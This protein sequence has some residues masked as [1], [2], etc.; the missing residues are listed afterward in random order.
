MS[1]TDSITA[2]VHPDSSEFAAL[3]EQIAAGAQERERTRERPYEV[4]DWLREAGF[5]R[6]RIPVEEGGAGLSVQE[7][8]AALIALAAA[9]SNAAH[10]LRVHFAFVEQQLVNPDAASRARWLDLVNSGAIIGN[11]QSEQNG[12]AVAGAGLETRAEPDPDGTGY[13]LTGVKYY[14]TGSLYADYIWVF[15]AAPDNR[16]AGIVIPADRDGVELVDDWDGFGQRLTGTGTTRFTDVY[17]EPD[18]YQDWGPAG[19]PLPPTVM[20]AFLQ[21]FLQAVTAGVLRAVR[22]DA[23]AL[24]RRRARSFG[25]AS[26]EAPAE[27]VQVLQ[28]VGEIAADAFAAEAIV[29]AAASRIDDAVATVVEGFPSLDAAYE[30]QVA[31]AQAKVAID[32]FSY[33]TAARLF[34]AGGASATQAAWQLDRHWRNVRTV[35]THNPTFL[36]ATAVGKWFVGGEAPPQNGFF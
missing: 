34:D 25:H 27:D 1:A 10:I 3:L 14:S 24:V 31:A 28:V 5:G 15:A 29:L 36:K 17:V 16:L 22:R 13:R 20:G 35:S 19:Q 30:A 23:A 33:A 11:A 9:D 7:L 26:A 2:P 21:L 12:K 18:E 32:R 6:L 4:I 8:F